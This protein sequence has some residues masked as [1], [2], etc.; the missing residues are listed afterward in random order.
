MLIRKI[1]IQVEILKKH[2]KDDHMRNAQLKPAYNVQI[3]VESEYISDTTTL[4]P[5]LGNM[6]NKLNSQ[7]SKIVADSRYESKENYIY[8]EDNNQ[9]PYIKPQ[10]Y[11]KW[12]NK[13]FKNDII[14]R[15]NM[16]YDAINYT[17]ICHNNKFKKA[18][19]KHLL[20]AIKPRLRYMN[21]MIALIVL[22]N[23]NVQKQREIVRCLYQKHL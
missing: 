18:V 14:K 1:F 5:L 13:S 8:L 20:P 22:V 21:V 9:I 10:T 7:Y 23:L 3:G 15:E 4:I 2:M 11:E 17:Y 16:E 19:G 12:K 6:K